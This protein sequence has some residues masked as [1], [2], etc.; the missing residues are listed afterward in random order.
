MTNFLNSLKSAQALEEMAPGSIALKFN[1]P[2]CE[3]VKSALAKVVSG[4]LESGA[5][6]IPS[7]ESIFIAL[8][9]EAPTASQNES[10][11]AS[12]WV[13]KLFS[14][15]GRVKTEEADEGDEG[16]TRRRRKKRPVR[17]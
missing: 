9:T 2:Q 1:G 7:V 5:T 3:K 17:S 6:E 16:K 14:K 15:P 8:L 13:E 11:A 10:P 12:E 4:I